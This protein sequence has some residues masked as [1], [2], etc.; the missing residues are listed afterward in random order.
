MAWELLVSSDFGLMS[1]GGIIFMIFF[2]IYLARRY[3]RKMN[4]E[5]GKNAK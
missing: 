3:V 4:E 1:L 2:C 5:S